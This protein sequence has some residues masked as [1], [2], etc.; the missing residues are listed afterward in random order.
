MGRGAGQDAAL[1]P[2]VAREEGAGTIVAVGLAIVLLLLLTALMW[3]GEAANAAAKAA[4]AAD[5]AALA[6]ADAAR[7]LTVGDPCQVAAD[8]VIRQ[9]AVLVSC[10]VVG[11]YA[12]TV[13]LEV[14]VQTGLPWPAYNKS[15]AGP[16]P[17]RVAP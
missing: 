7:G 13:Q 15:R 6:G 5:L 12:D 10:M 14:S 17:E 1:F 9:G 4:T 8:L 16:P 11:V 2:P 3:L